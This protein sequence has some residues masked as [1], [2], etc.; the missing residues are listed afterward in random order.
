MELYGDESGHLRSL[1]EGDEDL[2]VLAVVAGEAERCIRCPKRTVRNVTNIEE[3][4]WSELT[5]TQRRRMVECLIE[6][7]QDLSFGYVT[8]DQSALL[9]LQAHYRL[10]EDDLRYAWDLCVIADCYASI[11]GELLQDRSGHIF[12]FDRLFSKKMSGRIIETMTETT[13]EL[14]VRHED[15]RKVTGIQTADCFAGAVRADRLQGQNWLDQFEEVS[16][17]TESALVT[18]EE[19]LLGAKTGP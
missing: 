9:Q 3:A 15:S 12:T 14:K 8:I 19:R 2:F 1:L 5:D 18:V 7:E 6:C 17:V 4:K 10:Y 16:D 13:P 11:I